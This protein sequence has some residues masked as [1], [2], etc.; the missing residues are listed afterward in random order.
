MEDS[1]KIMT[2]GWRGFIVPL[3]II[4]TALLFVGDCYLYTREIINPLITVSSPEATSVAQSAVFSVSTFPEGDTIVILDND[5][6]YGQ[7]SASDL[8]V[9]CG[10]KGSCDFM[11]ILSGSWIIPDK[12]KV[13][14]EF[15]YP[16]LR[17]QNT[18]YYFGVTDL[19]GG[20]LRILKGA[21]SGK[22]TASNV[23]DV[24]ISPLGNF[25]SYIDSWSGGYCAN[26]SSLGVFDLQ[27]EK[28]L[29][30]PKLV[31]EPQGSIHDHISDVKWKNDS[32]LSFTDTPSSCASGQDQNLP[33][34]VYE[35]SVPGMVLR[36]GSSK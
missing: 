17:A 3:L 13:L 30:I 28:E 12:N 32:T 7:I 20:S 19:R 9:T 11:G 2:S 33:Q 29:I 25:F 22:L 16:T 10:G 35:L 36:V 24:S 14:F 27:E 34:V 21:D 1:Q 26:G 4:I 31:G 18:Q 5:S 23:R 6:V 15:L 8:P